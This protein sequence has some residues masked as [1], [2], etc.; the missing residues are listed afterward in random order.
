MIHKI[1]DLYI[2]YKE[3]INYLIFGVLTT[4]VNLVIKYILLFTIL[5]PT[6]AFQLQVA[7]IISWIAGVLFAYFTNRKFVFE[8]KNE[9][10]L[11][12]FI[13]FVVARISTL[14]LEMFI[15]WFFVTL[16]KLNSDLYVVIFTLVAQVAV[17]IGNYIFSKLF[18]FKKTD[19]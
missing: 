13:S 18:V 16:L 2:K 15:M 11:K 1:K 8:S 17:V 4:I 9:N 19:K 3:I 7:I 10:K 14:L 6:N 12:E 5:N